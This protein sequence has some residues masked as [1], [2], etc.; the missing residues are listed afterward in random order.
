MAGSFAEAR[1][2]ILS[3]QPAVL[4]AKA[5][6]V[7]SFGSASVSAGST[8]RASADRLG[9]QRGAPYQAYQERLAPTA[10]WL[11]GLSPLSNDTA[12]TL[13]ERRAGR[14]ARADGAG[15]AG[16]GA[17]PVRG[18]PEHDTGGV[19]G[20]GGPGPRRAQRGDRG[21]HLGLRGDH[22]RHADGRRPSW[23]AGGAPE[24]EQARRP[25][26][27]GV[28]G[29]VGAS[30]GG[31]AAAAAGRR[32]GAVPRPAP[33]GGAAGTAGRGGGR[34]GRGRADVRAV[35]RVRA[36]PDHRQPHRSRHRTAGRRRR[37]LPR[38]DHRPAVRARVTVRVAAG[39]ARRRREP[40]RR[41][42]WAARR[43]RRGSVGALAPGLAGAPVRVGRGR[44]RPGRR[45]EPC[46]SSPAVAPVPG[47]AASRGRGRIRVVRRAVRRRRAAEPGRDAT[48]RP[49]NCASRRRTNL[50]TMAGT[51]R[52]YSAIASGQAPG[53]YLPPM[54]GAGAGAAGGGGAGR[55]PRPEPAADRRA[56]E[57]VGC[58]ARCGRTSRPAAPAV[59][60]HRGGRG[61]RGLERRHDGAQ[62]P[63]GALSSRPA[64]SCRVGHRQISGARSASAG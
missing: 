7:R 57:R 16:G 55:P 12:A 10:G 62:P 17:G 64:E 60:V 33:D 6:E 5:G 47:C 45:R 4:R 38:P 46:P 25:P 23:R 63:R 43:A 3:L 40:G 31:V 34:R 28:G 22:P 36:G 56:G 52:R 9:A 44:C 2:Q 51:A 37:P 59:P 41:A 58:G 21:G 50:S 29:A 14:G 26:D 61:R 11:T 35:R 53:A 8:L 49:R 54:A 42:C 15:A 30:A 20:G 1:A 18:Q 48:R 19:R 27:Y 13:D 32:R 24:P 39:G